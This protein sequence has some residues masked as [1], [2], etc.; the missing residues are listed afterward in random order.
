MDLARNFKAA[1]SLPNQIELNWLAPVGFNNTTDELIVTKTKT[2]FPME[3]FN[4]SF[5]NRATDSRPVEIFRGSTIARTNS[6]TISVSG[7]TITDSAASFPTSPNL[8][9]RLLR[10]ASSHVFRIL[11]NTATSITLTG[12]PANGIF[13]VLP[14]FAAD[15]RIQD[16]YEFDIRTSAGPGYIQDLVIIQNNSFVIDT[17]AD[18]ELVNLI[19]KD[20]SGTKFIVKSNTANTVFFFEPGTPVIG[21]G[22]ATLT[23]H[24]NSQPLPYID[25]FRTDVQ[26]DARL[27]TGLEDDTFYYYTVFAKPKASP[28]VPIIFAQQTSAAIS[29]LDQSN[30]T[31]H[32]FGQSFK[33]LVTGNISD[34]KIKLQADTALGNSGTVVLKVYNAVSNLPTGAVL[35]TSAAVAA[36][37][38]DYVAPSL[39][40]FHFA[41]PISVT[42]N[43]N[44][45]FVVDIGSATFAA[46]GVSFIGD[47]GFPY[48]NGNQIRSTTGGATW[49]VFNNG[50]AY[51]DIQNPGTAVVISVA[52]ASFSNIDT[53]ASTQAYALS[54]KDTNFGNILYNLW[55]SLDR[56]LDSTEDLQDLMSI[57][58]FQL[59]ELHSLITTYNLQ[60]S[61][62]VLVTALLPLSE[63]TGL[64]SIGYS[65]GADTLRR[66]ARDM[67]RCWK[68]KG[69]KEGI[70]LFIRMLTTWDITNGTADF[71]SAVQDF[72]PNVMALRFYDPNLGNL[73]V[74]LTQTDPFVAGGRFAKGLPGI[75]IPG[76][77]TFREF[78]ITIPNVALYVG[79]SEDIST[80]SGTT[81]MTDTQNNFGPVDS[82]IGNFL[83][84]NTE[85][86]NDI[87]QIVG[88]TST[89]ITV[90][91]IANN[92]VAGGSYAV[93]SPLNTNRFI[94]LNRLLPVYIPFGTRAGFLFTIT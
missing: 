37:S 91:G 57:F 1:T 56:Q 2:H 27:G 38:I 87:F 49:S 81:T 13:V 20:G 63:Q 83:I 36:S 58:G 88:N 75:V 67:I 51:F 45:A 21:S 24:F 31:S 43:N 78:V 80:A 64:P 76:F 46:G 10:D 23:S 44:Y 47:G 72:L 12:P 48:T 32:W 55:P 86:I 85:E 68:L 93:L 5:P 25:N 26:A 70:A 7:N 8:V 65:I 30:S 9:G 73:N 62:K 60:D 69:S 79:T 53:A 29:P 22:M 19:F 84:P 71:S 90:R 15:I 40:N 18:D 59:N 35:Q 66:I 42:A 74:R 52:Q 89:T 34:I 3:L 77:F 4:A 54:T 82:L 14:D 6:G 17:F 41:T 11:S 50:D 94:I 39:V 61:D 92:R 28:A 33:S 16:N